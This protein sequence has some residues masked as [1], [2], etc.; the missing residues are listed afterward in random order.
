MFDFVR[1]NTRFLGL[2]MALFIVPGFI[3]MG[4]DGY[5]NFDRGETVATVAGSSI[6]REEWDNAHRQEVDRIR[7]QQPN[8]DIKQFDTD[9]ARYLTLERLV[10]ERVLKEAARKSHLVTSNQ[11]LAN[12]LQRNEVIATLRK[13]DGSLDMDR[14]KQLL[15]AQGMSP[16]M[17]EAQ[18][19]QDLSMRQ[20]N[21]GVTGSA[22]A[23]PGAAKASLD[24][25]F[26]RREVQWVR[27]E[28]AKQTAKVQIS[29]DDIAAYYNAHPADFQ[30][31][32]RADVE[33]VMLDLA[34][35]TDA[36]QVSDA[37]VKA[38]YDQNATRYSTKEER[39]ASHIL[40]N[41][42][43]KAPAAER[44]AA[45]A[46]AE[47]L[48]AQ[49]RKNPASF[50][51]LA[52]KNSQDPG[53]APQGGDLSYFQRGAMVKPFEDAAFG[54]KKGDVSDVVETEFGYH[55]IHVTDIKPSV[56]RPLDQVKPEI[57]A[58]LKKQQAQREFAEKA[59]LFGNLV[60]E[61][62]ETYAPVAEKLKLKVQTY[63]GLTRVPDAKTPAVLAQPKA[64]EA[65]FSADALDKK[66]NTEAL[67]IGPNQL[68]SVRVTRHQP[69]Q[70]LP[71][72]DVKTRV[73]EVLLNERAQVLAKTEGEKALAAWKVGGD[74]KLPAAVVVSRNKPEGLQTREVLAALSADLT[75]APAWV[76][77]DLGPQGYTV[78]KVLKV[79]PREAPS[80]DTAKQEVQQYE[81]WWASAEGQAYY[82]WLKKRFKVDFKVAK[83]GADQK[84]V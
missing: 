36:I 35:V 65:V 59:D 74:A 9:E 31:A 4:V 23:T 51:E 79:Q 50:A 19:R 71:L 12:E 42:A 40:I 1:N 67:E 30:Q 61:Q 24:A 39:R 68:L 8:I 47:E 72:A 76:G 3:L 63:A 18:M 46:K 38:Y 6:K 21:Q 73:R 48:L 66:R 37:D 16:E 28:T 43:A 70:T 25:F 13:P 52:K 5:R 2:L 17:F 57:V 56:V 84:K 75:Q 41:A 69:A 45:K 53:S 60:Y 62:A 80:A 11:K 22:F 58:E 20:V 83:P 29:D 64:I 32:E 33:Y 27:F 77:V 10:R 49:V 26:E 15:A 81:Q 7:A 14:Y 78:L 54:L 55:I 34:A 44:E 82:E